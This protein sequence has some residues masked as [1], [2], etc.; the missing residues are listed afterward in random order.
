MAH[1]GVLE[2]DADV[3]NDGTQ[4]TGVFWFVGNAEVSENIQIQP[5]M[6]TGQGSAVNAITTRSLEQ[7]GDL[8]D[9][10]GV[11]TIGRRGFTL[12]LGGGQHGFSVNFQGWEG[13]QDANGNPVTW[14]TSD[15]SY[16]DATG[17]SPA[18]QKAVFFEFLRRGEYDSRAENARFRYGEYSDGTYSRDGV[19]T[20][21][22]DYIHVEPRVIELTRT[23]EDPLRYSGHLEMREIAKWDEV[24]DAIGEVAW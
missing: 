16:F 6:F 23:A 12:D 10:S 24:I 14:G 22:D 21:L 5:L 1:K 3:D 15:G 4:E 18:K 19:N 20:D 8:I 7:V 2:L 17:D 9:A 11:Y 13:A